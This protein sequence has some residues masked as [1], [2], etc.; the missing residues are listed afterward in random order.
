MRLQGL[1]A[2]VR[3]ATKPHLAA[4]Q[5]AK[6]LRQALP[7]AQANESVWH[8][9]TGHGE[10]ESVESPHAGSQNPDESLTTHT[11]DALASVEVAEASAEPSEM[12]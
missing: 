10:R 8:P 5:L 2:G 11:A 4:W 1:G 6:K 9:S 3:A 12:L 7:L